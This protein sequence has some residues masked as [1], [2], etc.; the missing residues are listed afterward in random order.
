VQ[1]VEYLAARGVN[2]AIREQFAIEFAPAERTALPALRAD[3]LRS[4]M[5]CHRS[6]P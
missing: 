4:S 6:P 5:A 3:V 2:D 1:A